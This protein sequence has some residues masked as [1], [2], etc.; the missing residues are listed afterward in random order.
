VHADLEVAL[1]QQ[2]AKRELDG[3]TAEKLNLEKVSTQVIARCGMMA[4]PLLIDLLPD[5]RVEVR[6]WSAV[7]LGA[8]GPDASQAIPVLQ[9]LLADPDAAV[10][11]HAQQAL[12][13]IAAG[14]FE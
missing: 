10:R 13:S 2:E 4:V 6:R 12:R 9:E 11:M 3:L 8:I 1:I 7:T 5:E 14:Q